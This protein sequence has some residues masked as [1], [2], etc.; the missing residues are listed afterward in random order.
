[1]GKMTRLENQHETAEVIYCVT[2][3]VTN[4]ELNALFAAAWLDH[5]WRDFRPVLS[6]SLAFISA[7]H[8]E[9]LI[10]FVN[11]AWDGGIH[12]FVLD[13]TV[14]PNYR[15]QGIGRQLVKYAV[16]VAQDRGIEW[17]HVDFEPPLQNFYQACEFQP[18]KAGLIQLQPR[19]RI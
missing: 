1:M 4:D 8:V 12:A 14:H 19:T 2:P 6:R 15:R 18:T 7:Y 11:L 16:T 17:L 13:T 9:H 10:G 3:S 5:R